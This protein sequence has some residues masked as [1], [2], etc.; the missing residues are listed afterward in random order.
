MT[1]HTPGPW[2]IQGSPNGYKT[3]RCDK[4]GEIARM[5]SENVLADDSSAA[6][7]AHLI[8]AAPELLAALRTGLW[9][10]QRARDLTWSAYRRA[11]EAGYHGNA[12]DLHQAWRDTTAAIKVIENCIAKA[13]GEHV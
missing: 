2:F 11:I 6:A 13:T 7:N 3:V 8:A 9:Q 10:S 4:G 1:N 12:A 5:G